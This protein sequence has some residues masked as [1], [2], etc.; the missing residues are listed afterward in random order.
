MQTVKDIKCILETRSWIMGEE[1]SLACLFFEA[2]F[3][4]IFLKEF[5]EY[6]VGAGVGWSLRH[7]DEKDSDAETDLWN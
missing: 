7:L 2:V 5:S 6:G 3:V 4:E 1:A